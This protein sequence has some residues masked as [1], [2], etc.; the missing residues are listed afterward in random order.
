MIYFTVAVVFE[1]LL[2]ACA[3]CPAF[4]PDQK[5]ALEILA[6]KNRLHVFFSCKRKKVVQSE[7]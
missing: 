1:D 5:V 3:G 7:C 6:L 2:H 4:C